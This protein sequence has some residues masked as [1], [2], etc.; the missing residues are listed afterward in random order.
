MLSLIR[1]IDD[2]DEY[3]E[4]AAFE[5]VISAKSNFTLF[6]LRKKRNVL[7]D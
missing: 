1:I 5:L 2:C 3:I 6:E 7:P 4:L